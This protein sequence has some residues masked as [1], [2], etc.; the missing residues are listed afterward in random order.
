MKLLFKQRFLSWFD[1]Y[2]IYNE[3][4]RVEYRVEGQF[5]WGHRLH[6]HNRYDEHIATLQQRVFTFLPAFDLYI[7][8]QQ[9]GT[10]QKEFSFFT[11]SYILDCKG[12]HIEGEFLEWD[13]EIKDQSGSVVAT[14]SK[15]LFNWTDTYVID[16]K[17]S[18]DALFVL[19]VV[20]AI[21][22]EKCSRD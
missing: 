6:I 12:W 15:E 22:A 4:G 3:D 13:Y 11:P 10:I 1:S 16:A 9:I 17:N 7:G 19:M 14:A 20:L 5:S 8:D 2:D 21:D 18:E